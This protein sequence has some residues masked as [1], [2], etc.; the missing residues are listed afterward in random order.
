[1]V[2]IKLEEEYSGFQ[3][4]GGPNN[5]IDFCTFASVGNFV[6]FGDANVASYFDGGCSDSTRTI[7]AGGIERLLQLIQIQ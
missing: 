2:E 6:D 4:P 7:K 5:T 3:S 1:M